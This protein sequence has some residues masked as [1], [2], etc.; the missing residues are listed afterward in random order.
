MCAHV[1]FPYP[2]RERLTLRNLRIHCSQLV[3]DA[4]GGQTADPGKTQ[5][6][7]SWQNSFLLKEGQFLFY[8][9]FGLI[10]GAHSHYGE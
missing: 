5:N 8:S 1:C 10:G 7:V 9:G 3:K 2:E 4:V 6:V